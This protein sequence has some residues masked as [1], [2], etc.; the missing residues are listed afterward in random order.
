MSV[1]DKIQFFG[2]VD[3]RH[4][5]ADERIA[6]EYPAFYFPTKLEELKE[7][8]DK[9]KR[10]ISM[11]LIPASELPYAKAELEKS[12]KRLK[13]IKSSLPKLSGKEKDALAK[14]YGELGEQIADAMFTRTAMKK[15]LADAH[16]EAR[17]MSEPI[18]K[19]G[20]AGKM[21]ENMGITPVDGKVSRNQA[22][23][24]WKIIGKV[25]GES[26]NTE[27]LRRDMK[28]GVYMAEKSLEEIIGG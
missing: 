28:T 11:G 2:D 18:I 25:L 24:A 21:F 12:E 5:R 3:R 20:D 22:S 1:L 14:V 23:R 26:S 17:R 27:S 15:G 8:I 16:E 9:T 6:S 19:V 10:Q 4:K 7:N 13:E